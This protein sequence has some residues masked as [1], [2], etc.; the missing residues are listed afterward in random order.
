MATT[1]I[2]TGD[3]II[4]GGDGAHIYYGA[5]SEPDPATGVN[6][7]IYIQSNGDFYLKEDGNWVLLFNVIG[8][9]APPLV[10]RGAWVTGMTVN[11]SDFVYAVS[12]TDVALSS[13]YVSKSVVQFVSN[14]TPGSDL[15]HWLEFSGVP[16]Q[17]GEKGQAGNSGLSGWTP[18]LGVVPDGNRRVLKVVDWFGGTGEK[19]AINLYLGETGFVA[20]IADATDIS[21]SA[22][23]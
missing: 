20:A 16:G 19:P 23:S 11:P 10:N 5:V 15:D 9:A 2:Q 4:I 6:N 8:P 14:T 3:A 1:V 7:D 17:K 22:T 21:G 12:S 18:N 13:I